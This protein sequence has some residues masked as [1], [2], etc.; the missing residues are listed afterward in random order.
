MQ[1]ANTAAGNKY[2]NGPW[3]FRVDRT[4]SDIQSSV[5]RRKD[6]EILVKL[7]IEQFLRETIRNDPIYLFFDYINVG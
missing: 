7:L 5:K 1:H 4:K 2:Y 3:R 6:V